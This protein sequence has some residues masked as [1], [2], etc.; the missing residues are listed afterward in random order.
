MGSGEEASVRL[1]LLLPFSP[2]AYRS[3]RGH[4]LAW[5]EAH[6]VDG[7]EWDA[8]PFPPGAGSSAAR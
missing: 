5:L 3:V 6:P 4:G 8:F 1:L 2:E 7:T